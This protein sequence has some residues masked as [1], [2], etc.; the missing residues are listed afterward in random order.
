MKWVHHSATSAGD[1]LNQAP[2]GQPV[3]TASRNAL[4]VQLAA[5]RDALHAPD[6]VLND[7]GG[8]AYLPEDTYRGREAAWTGK[9]A[10]VVG[11]LPRPAAWVSTAAI[12][13]T[14]SIDGRRRAASTAITRALDLLASS[15]HVFVRQGTA[16]AGDFRLFDGPAAVFGDAA[17]A[18]V[19]DA[20]EKSVHED[21]DIARLVWQAHT[22]ALGVL[23]MLA[24]ARR[25]P[26]AAAAAMTEAEQTAMESVFE[27]AEQRQAE[28]IDANNRA[29]TLAQGTLLA[30]GLLVGADAAKRTANRAF[31][32]LF[33]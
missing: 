20:G 10:P 6:V 19:P 21:K 25:N 18:L 1:W 9:S 26:L 28:A 33:G 23:R 27:L 11:V 31:N 22:A 4:V 7:E 13:T 3:P 8:I 17:R 16:P 15:G 2:T 5:I 29:N 14:G 30:L 24:T 32:R 12:D